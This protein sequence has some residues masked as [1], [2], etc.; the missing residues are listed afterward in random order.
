MSQANEEQLI[1]NTKEQLMKFEEMSD[2]DESIDAIDLDISDEQEI[3][4]ILEAKK[5]TSIHKYNQQLNN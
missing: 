5:V 1:N 3:R 2:S 4:S